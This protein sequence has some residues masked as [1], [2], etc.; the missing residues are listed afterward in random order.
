M[1]TQQ[2]IGKR[3][4]LGGG[5]IGA[6]LVIVLFLVNYVGAL[7]FHLVEGPDCIFCG[8]YPLMFPF[9]VFS[10][11]FLT[12]FHPLTRLVLGATDSLALEYAYVVFIDC[13]SFFLLGAGVGLIVGKLRYRRKSE[14]TASN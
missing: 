6:A 1:T 12:L 9:I 10:Q 14:P 2:T 4:W 7:I 8:E 5:L 3:Y 11:P 13:V